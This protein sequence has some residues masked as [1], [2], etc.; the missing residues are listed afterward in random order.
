MRSRTPPAA[1][2]IC[3][4]VS[5]LLAF[6][7]A[8]VAQ[9]GSAA[10][11]G[12]V[13]NA[14]TGAFLEG[15]E[16]VVVGTNL[17]V[18]TARDGSFEL[19]RPT[20]DQRLRISYSGLTAQEVSVNAG[21]ATAANLDIAL[22][23]DVYQMEAFSVTSQRE[24]DAVAIAR[25][26]AATNV[27]NVVSLEGKEGVAEGNLGNFLQQLPGVVGNFQAGDV[28]G[29]GVR[30]VPPDM[31]GVTMDGQRM[32]SAIAG[33]SPVGDRAAQIDQIS[34][35]F[36]KE[37][38]LYKANTPDVDPASLGGGVDIITKSALDYRNRVF[39]YRLGGTYN[40][41]RDDVHRWGPSGS[42]TYMDTFG[43]EKRWGITF[44]GSYTRTIVNRDTM[45]TGRT[46]LTDKGARGI[47]MIDDM[48]DRI[49]TG[50]GVKLEYRPT[51]V[52]SLYVNAQYNY[53]TFDGVRHD[54]GFG[55][56]G[57]GAEADR[58]ADYSIVSRAA[59]EAGATPRTTA[60]LV[61]GTAPGRTDDRFELINPRLT[62][63]AAKEE[64]ES[65]QFKVSAGGELQI[66]GGKLE[67]L[68]SHNPTSFD[69][70]YMGIITRRDSRYGIL[71][72]ST[73]DRE[74]PTI[75]QTFGSTVF[76][77]RSYN[78]WVTDQVYEQ[79]DRSEE[80][81]SVISG[82]F[83]RRFH[84]GTVALTFKWGAQFRRQ[85]Q[86][87]YRYRPIWDYRGPDGVAGLNP[88]TGQNDDNLAQFRVAEPGYSLFNNHFGRWDFLSWSAVRKH[89]QV[90]SLYLNMTPGQLVPRADVRSRQ[91]LRAV[92]EDV[93]AAYAMGTARVGSLSVLTGLRWEQTEIEA[94]GSFADPSSP[95]QTI[96][97]RSDDYTKI[98]PSVHFRYEPRRN[99]VGRASWSTTSA[100]PNLAQL[101]PDMSVS[102]D[103]D[104]NTV[105]LGRVTVNN[106][107]L[108]PNYSHNYDLAFDYY[109]EPAGVVS[110]GVFYKDIKDWIVSLND[111][112]GTGAGNGFNGNYAGY[113][114][115]TQTN[116]NS[117]T[118]KGYELNYVQRLNFLPKPFNGL[119]FNANY[120]YSKTRGTYA[121]GLS[122]LGNFVPKTYNLGLSYSWRRLLV[123]VSH[124]H[125][126]NY[127]YRRGAADNSAEYIAARNNTGINVRFKLRPWATL[128]FDVTDLFDEPSIWY[129]LRDPSRVSTVEQYGR[130]MSAGVTGR[131]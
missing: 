13:R 42:F 74:R 25:Q 110:A 56:V 88:A 118:I 128:Y 113:D 7:S 105:A 127:L 35:D 2:C 52:L 107:G 36:I 32:A 5:L 115:T 1:R 59:I 94:T 114:L 54:N 4:L 18:F 21:T 64:K 109:L 46:T 85:E 31:T 126:S 29:I 87:R 99:F 108:L 43:P 68:V 76:H 96:T 78:D 130:R 101:Y 61:A 50:G 106:V 82:N 58:P 93:T 51:S 77:G 39:N 95:A 83:D 6:S 119:Q 103:T 27:M 53:F 66:L 116:L 71:V 57:G 111:T 11:R 131:F 124:N 23:S 37:V 100:R 33:F 12:K 24:G 89:F 104:P 122:E 26:R 62:Y 73:A 117:A 34:P 70:N 125:R 65:R 67:L 120:T 91:P 72:D 55:S 20:A 9:T 17:S 129:R 90:P 60:N 47:R 86:E 48:N 121:S 45:E 38:R 79:S 75:T 22:T 112:V 123:S 40:H 30:G 10:I 15:A 28:I 44:S 19:P 63:R 92:T 81:M 69:N 84:L 14:Q 102:H 80:A 8:L 3:A 49:R 41:F 98:F 16:V 97:N